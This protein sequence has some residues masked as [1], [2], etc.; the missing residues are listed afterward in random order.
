MSFWGPPP[1][2]VGIDWESIIQRK[3]VGLLAAVPFLDESYWLLCGAAALWV[4]RWGLSRVCAKRLR[5][6]AYVL[7]RRGQLTRRSAVSWAAHENDTAGYALTVLAGRECTWREPEPAPAAHA[8]AA[9]ILAWSAL[10][11][12][13]GACRQIERVVSVGGYTDYETERHCR[14]MVEELRDELEV[15]GGLPVAMPEYPPDNEAMRALHDCA[16]ER[17]CE[18]LCF[19]QYDL[20]RLTHTMPAHDRKPLAEGWYRRV[21]MHND[22]SIELYRMFAARAGRGDDAL[23]RA[24]FTARGTAVTRWSSI[25]EE[26]TYARSTDVVQASALVNG[27]VELVSS[28]RIVRPSDRERQLPAKT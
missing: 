8:Q 19:A 17:T 9:Q 7:A 1:W 6:A 23:V 26:G 18:F 22:A 24:L 21:R 4:D 5:Q 3:K 15:I 27:L 16:I 12:A 14:Q 25:N 2:D 10:G 13:L 28:M 20:V 11:L